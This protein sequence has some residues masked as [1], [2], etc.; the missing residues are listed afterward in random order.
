MSGTR[1]TGPGQPASLVPQWL[2]PTDLC[3]F[4]RQHR[5]GP[6]GTAGSNVEEAMSEEKIVAALQEL[7][8]TDGG[9]GF[10]AP[11]SEEKSTVSVSC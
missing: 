7:P 1:Q 11:P 2:W 5:P 10:V 8:E 3:Q 4:E 9:P 6:T